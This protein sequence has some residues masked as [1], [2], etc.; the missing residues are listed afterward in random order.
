VFEAEDPRSHGGV[1]KAHEKVASSQ[2]PAGDPR[3]Q[4]FALML[5][6]CFTLSIQP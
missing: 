3:A 5:V 4:I 1:Q 6:G 2:V